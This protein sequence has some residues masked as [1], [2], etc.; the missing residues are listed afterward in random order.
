MTLMTDDHFMM[1]YAFTHPLRIVAMLNGTLKVEFDQAHYQVLNHLWYE[2]PDETSNVIR[3]T[4]GEPALAAVKELVALGIVDGDGTV[5]GFSL[6]TAGL[7]M[8][9]KIIN[10]L[11][12]ACKIVR[13]RNPDAGLT[14]TP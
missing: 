14:D 5:D 9:D 8:Q 13:E 6:T 10:T 4:Y 11:A 12:T 3:F 1:A 7:D 2:E